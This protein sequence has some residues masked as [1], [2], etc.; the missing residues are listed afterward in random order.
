M[1]RFF[2]ED[3]EGKFLCGDVSDIPGAA[4]AIGYMVVAALEELKRDGAENQEFVLS[5][6]EMSDEEVAALPEM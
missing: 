2:I 3:G 4:Q 6:K 1:L 5:A